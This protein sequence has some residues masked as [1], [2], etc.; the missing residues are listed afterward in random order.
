MPAPNKHALALEVWR[1]FNGA[2]RLTTP[3]TR[4][5]F[6]DALVGRLRLADDVDNWRWGRKSRHSHTG[7]RSDD[8][9]AYWLGDAPPPSAPTDGQVDAI[10]VI[11]SGG[12]VVWLVDPPEAYRN[13]F[14]MWWPLE[15]QPSTGGGSGGSSGGGGT[16]GGDDDATDAF[17]EALSKMLLEDA[18]RIANGLEAIAETGKALIERID[19][20]QRDGVK[21]R[22]R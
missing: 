21:L 18:T 11:T 8:T 7:P 16:G 5:G 22:L 15:G 10:D 17:L 20:L 6:V 14:A 4:N 1:A 2:Q 13:I 19:T 12:D 3:E 9:I